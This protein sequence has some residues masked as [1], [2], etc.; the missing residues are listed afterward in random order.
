[1]WKKLEGKVQSTMQTFYVLGTDGQKYGPAD[2]GILLQWKQ[3]ER[4]WPDTVL[5]STT[6]GQKLVAG[7]LPALGF[8]GNGVPAPAVPAS[9][10]ASIASNPA[11][12]EEP[13]IPTHPGALQS[14][15]PRFEAVQGEAPR[16]FNFGAFFFG[17]LWGCF[18]KKP[19]LLL[20]IPAGFVP[21]VGPFLQLGGSIYVGMKANRWAWES[22]RFATT[23]DCRACQKK[24]T[25]WAIG[26]V[27]LG[28]ILGAL[29]VFGLLAGGGAKS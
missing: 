28:L 27:V 7:T 15:Y 24:W 17:W 18:H 16:G 14:N 20:L 11:W 3:E 4:L 23:E 6:N 2:L 19:I 10:P 26:F 8:A 1:M 9:H 25:R 21:F 12:G 29:A 22:G 13:T 5:E